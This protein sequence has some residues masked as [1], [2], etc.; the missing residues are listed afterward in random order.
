MTTPNAYLSANSYL[1]LM[2][3]ATRGTLNASGTPV[4]IPVTSPQVTP[5]QKFLRDE[6]LRGSPTMVYNQVQGVR[7]DEYEF[8]SYLFADTFPYLLTGLLGTDTATNTAGSQYKHVINLLNSVASASQPA[9]FSILDFDGANGFVIL[10]AQQDSLDITFGAEA[11]AEATAK[12]MG[13]PYT[14]YTTGTIPTPFSATAN[15]SGEYPIASW[16]A[17]IS[18]GGTASGGSVTGGTQF[19][20]ISSGEL[21]IERKTAPIFTMLGS[22]NNGPYTNFAGPIEVSGKFTGV[23]AT[24]SDPWSTG[25]NATALNHA[26]V[27]IVISLTDPNDTAVTNSFTFQMSSAQ[28]QNVKR[29]RGKEY[30]EVEVE[31]TTNANSND[32]G[33]GSGFSPLLATVLNG[34]AAAS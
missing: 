28:F 1:G 17:N 13:N 5:Q 3:E 32:I 10:G 21:K 9:S 18:I 15:P 27:P 22:S 14:S 6:A 12:F 25:S 33:A 23:V 19:T 26:N 20:Y 11:L 29:T 8:K 34:I 24:T 30:V 2:P 7:N 31:F 4:Y 16:V